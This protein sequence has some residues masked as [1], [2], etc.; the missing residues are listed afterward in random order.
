MNHLRASLAVLQP[1][2]ACLQV[3]VLPSQTHDLAAPAAGQHQQADGGDRRRRRE[4]LPLCVTQRGAETA[5][6]LVGQ[7]PLAPVLGVFL[8]MPA[9]VDALGPHLPHLGKRQ[10]AREHAQRP[11]GMVGNVAHVVMKG[12]DVALADIADAA[13][14]ETGEDAVV[15][16]LA[17]EPCGAGLQMGGGVLLHE[18]LGQVGHGGA[19]PGSGR[20]SGQIAAGLCE[21]DDLCGLGPRRSRGDRPVR[22]DGDF[23]GSS[24]VSV[25]DD[26]DLS[27][28]RM[29]AHAEALDVV[30][31]DDALA[32]CGDEG[33]DGSL[34]DFRQR[35][36]PCR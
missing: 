31:P 9:R 6:L 15:D 4:A 28:G 7:K 17:V 8:D 25:L 23:D 16:D 32:L 33:I 19:S 10:H 36:F 26:V 5:V 18:A 12:D 2:L 24:L 30:I 35:N 14:A 21:G 34:G 22:P 27:P 3:D 29:D 1:D 20:L 13:L 11:I